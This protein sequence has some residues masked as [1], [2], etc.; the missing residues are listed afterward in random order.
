M[1]NEIK[2]ET[3]FILISGMVPS[4]PEWDRLIVAHF[5][6]FVLCGN[7]KN[8][9]LRTIVLMSAAYACYAGDLQ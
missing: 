8:D 4:L 5:L 3:H 1:A 2:N 9:F 7:R 6:I